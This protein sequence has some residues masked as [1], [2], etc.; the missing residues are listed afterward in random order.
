MTAQNP[1]SNQIATDWISSDTRFGTWT[2]LTSSTLLDRFRGCLLGGAVGDALGAP[3]EFDSAETIKA[4]FGPNGIGDFV[5]AY[6]RI[7][8]IT[9]D[10]QMTMFTTEGLIRSWTRFLSRGLSSPIDTVS[11]AYQRWL[12]TQGGRPHNSDQFFEKYV[13]T[14][15]LLEIDDLHSTRAPGLTCL[16][17]LEQGSPVLESKG[18]G[19]VMRVAPVGLFAATGQYNGSAFELGSDAARITHGHPSG[20]ISAGALAEI[21]FLIVGNEYSIRDACNRVLELLKTKEDATEVIRSLNLA[22][23]S[24]AKIGRDTSVIPTLGEGWVAEEALSI[25]VYCALVADSFEDGV[26]LAV[27]HS[28]DSDSTGSITGQILGAKLGSQPIPTRWTEKLELHNE[29]GQLAADLYSI[30]LH[31]QGFEFTSAFIERYPP[32]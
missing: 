30:S 21:V 17:G 28:G 27:N 15:W 5:E 16:G 14:G 22:L 2:R 13:L 12:M 10:T 20:H 8:A 31:D 1:E 23:E 11:H 19:G 24:A 3:V 29:I 9:D 26:R 18:C 4:K 32:N 25:S 7:G 6:G